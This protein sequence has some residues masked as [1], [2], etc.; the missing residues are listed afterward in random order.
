MTLMDKWKLTNIVAVKSGYSRMLFPFE[1]RKSKG[2]D[3]DWIYPGNV[4]SMPDDNTITVASGDTMWGIC[5]NFL[6]KEINNDE[7]A[8]RTLI[9]KTKTK[10]LTVPEAKKELEKIKAGSHSDM[11][12]EFIDTLLVQEN[13]KGWEP[14]DTENKTP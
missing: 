12:V 11:V 6:I 4:L 3:P 9:E 14:K 10:E 13:F 8:I 7:I 5:E 1:K 2:R